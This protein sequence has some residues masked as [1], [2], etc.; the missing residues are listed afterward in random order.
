MRKKLIS[1]AIVFAMILA[2]GVTV[3]AANGNSTN[4][5]V[6]NIFLTG[7]VDYKDYNNANFHCNAINGNGRVWT[8]LGKDYTQQMNDVLTFERTDLRAPQSVASKDTTWLLVNRA[9][10]DPIMSAN[11][12]KI[13]GWKETDPKAEMFICEQCGSQ[14]WVS[15]SNNSGEPDGKNI[16]ITH[17]GKN[18]EIVKVWL[19]AEG[20]AIKSTGLSAKFTITWTG[21]DGVERSMKNVGPGK[22]SFPEDLID[23]IVVTEVSVTKNYTLVGIEGRNV[24]G[25]ISGKLDGD[26][27]TFTN[28]EDPH[29]IIHKE[30]DIGGKIT[31]GGS[32]KITEGEGLDAVTKT[33]IAK[34][35]IYE[36]DEDAN[37][38]RGT[39][40]KAGLLANEKF[41]TAP[42]KYVVAEQPMVGFDAQPD[43]VIEVGEYEVGTCTFVNTPAGVYSA[44]LSFTKMVEGVTIVEW[45][46]DKG[47]DPG[48]IAAVL[49]GLEFTLEGVGT[50]GDFH[51]YG[52]VT[53]DPMY[54][55][56][57]FPAG[58]A[59]GTYTLSEEVKAPAGKYFGKM[60]D[61]QIMLD[62]GD[63]K[64]FIIPGSGKITIQGADFEAGSR[65]TIVNGY[66]KGY[67]LG[68][69]GLNNSGDIFP[70]AVTDTSNGN[71]YPSF[72]AHGGSANFA[73]Q[74]GLG[75]AGY[76]IAATSDIF[77]IEGVD[78]MDFVKAYNTIE[79]LYGNLDENRVITQIVTWILLGDAKS[80]GIAYPSES[81]DKIN[82]AAVEAGTTDV[83]GVPDAQ[84]KIEDVMANYKAHSGVGNIASVVYMLCEEG[85]DPAHCQPQLVPLYGTFYVENTPNG[86]FNSGVSFN[87]VMFGGDLE[88]G[89]D[90]IADNFEFK[91]FKIEGGTETYVD[92][93]GVDFYGRVS[94]DDL[95]PGNYVFREVTKLFWVEPVY[96]LD[97]NY[98]L[99]WKAIYPCDDAGCP[100]SGGLFFTISVT[101]E[102]VWP[103]CY[104]LDREGNPTVNNVVYCK[105][106]AFW[107]NLDFYYGSIPHQVIPFEGGQ[108]IVF[109]GFCS[110][111]L[112]IIGSNA[113]SCWGRGIVHFKCDLCDICT[114][115][116]YG[117]Q[118]EHDYQPTGAF[119]YDDD[120]NITDEWF[121]CTICGSAH[122]RPVEPAE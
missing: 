92:T 31:K 8:T 35:D 74:S 70:I 99:V 39:L 32:I 84:E 21:K 17:P 10:Q 5:K 118:I 3:L 114:S 110:G 15:F 38:M 71:V 19:D 50:D 42:G 91:L 23:S 117:E 87:K 108:I 29:A 111:D 46:K 13:E 72:C 34:F 67:T 103:A 12:K 41:Y 95:A 73:G 81:F 55:V 120:G 83:K 6:S 112:E 14:Q 11:G 4:G 96:G 51:K 121:E 97:G 26:A 79:D 16:Q 63:N 28:K 109:D 56:V 18:I 122:T 107:N 86:E 98:N 78:Y 89:A 33:V 113:P 76:M 65:F 40:L 119:L 54:G 24:M 22:Y 68:Y 1:L 9:T 82:W 102:T 100:F 105:H 43:Q 53:P 2:L 61:I 85:H 44:T 47:F 80:K 45:L 7:R 48:Q 75:C 77:E 101:G 49:A 116:A 25:V 30:W 115:I 59:P 36:Y 57:S 20:N 58:M 27:I 93:Y 90:N 88:Y 66:G 94:V 52:P 62:N 104:G 106:T 60:D 37:G 69:P 64:S